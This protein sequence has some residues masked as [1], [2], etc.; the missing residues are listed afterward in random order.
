MV[1][2]EGFWVL[3]L[4]CW[5]PSRKGT[6]QPLWAARSHA[7]P[8]LLY[9][10]V[11]PKENSF[12]SKQ[13][14]GFLF[15]LIPAPMRYQSEEPSRSVLEAEQ[16]WLAD[17]LLTTGAQD[18]FSAPLLHS[19]GWV[20]WCLSCLRKSR[21][22]F[23]ILDCSPGTTWW[24]PAVIPS[25]CPGHLWFYIS[26]KHYSHGIGGRWSISI[27]WRGEKGN[28]FPHCLGAHTA[29]SQSAVLSSDN[30]FFRI[31]D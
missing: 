20:C 6:A 2:G 16:G 28:V 1:S 25:F 12:S 10:V 14:E 19:L 23:S 4:Q 5:K 13:P 8:S 26:L 21:I 9:T 15:H 3:P 29:R 30:H 11:S 24:I 7:V 17:S 27:L 18:H 31:M 22:G